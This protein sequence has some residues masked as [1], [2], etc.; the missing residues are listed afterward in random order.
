[1]VD[2]NTNTMAL[3]LCSWLHDPQ[4]PTPFLEEVRETV[5]SARETFARRGMTI[6]DSLRKSY[7]ERVAEHG[8]DQELL[9]WA[10]RA[11]AAMEGS[12]LP[13]DPE[14]RDALSPYSYRGFQLTYGDLEEIYGADLPDGS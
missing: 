10:A 5:S 14:H 11:A 6:D 9:T 13:R 12:S 4:N 3:Y 2:P 1:M 7:E 8:L